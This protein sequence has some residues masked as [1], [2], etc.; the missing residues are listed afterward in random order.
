MMI[1]VVF[2]LVP[3]VQSNSVYHAQ[4]RALFQYVL[5]EIDM[6]VMFKKMAMTRI[7]KTGRLKGPFKNNAMYASTIVAKNMTMEFNTETGWS[8]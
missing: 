6:A 4:R 3:R 7:E 1:F 8:L 2:F 5:L